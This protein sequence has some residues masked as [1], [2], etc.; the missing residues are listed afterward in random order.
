MNVPT[1]VSWK[2]RKIVLSAAEVVGPLSMAYHWRSTA[3]FWTATGF[4]R[5]VLPSSLETEVPRL[6][7]DSRSTK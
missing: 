2:A 5:Q 7:S 6:T 1:A 4:L 3:A